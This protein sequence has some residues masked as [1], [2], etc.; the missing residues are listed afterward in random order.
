MSVVS[1]RFND[2]EEEIVKNYVKSK[3]TNLSQ[4]IKNIIFETCSRIPKRKI[5]RDI[6]SKTIWGSSK[7]MGTRK[8][9][10]RLIVDIQDE[11]LIIVIVDF[12]HRS[13]I[14]L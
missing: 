3:G 11:Q 14:Y 2:E 13:K 6:K 9:D 5:W 7:R 4:Y 10:Y 12:E 1:I 8:I